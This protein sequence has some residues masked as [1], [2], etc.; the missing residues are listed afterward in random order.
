MHENDC[1]TPLVILLSTS[2]SM[3]NEKN[4]ICQMTPMYDYVLISEL[5]SL[6]TRPNLFIYPI[7]T[8]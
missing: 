8:K 6:N 4:I 3:I 7:L 1:F 2:W 5:I